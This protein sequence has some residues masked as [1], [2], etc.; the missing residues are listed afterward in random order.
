MSP[1]V[2]G[3]AGLG[4]AAHP[5]DAAARPGLGLL[6]RSVRDNGIGM[7]P[8]GISR[9]FQAFSQAEDDTMERFG[10]TGLGLTIAQRRGV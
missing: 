3:W 10:G 5:C 1:A 4:W 2:G 8:E 6:L 9:L 7:S